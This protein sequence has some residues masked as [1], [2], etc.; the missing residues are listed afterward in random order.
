MA[1]AGEAASNVH[2]VAAAAEELGS[3]VQE[4]G[5]QVGGST[6]LAHLAVSEADQTSVLMHEL[7]SAVARISEPLGHDTADRAGLSDA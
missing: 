6:E 5:R 4:I 1:A 3:S 7:S 2:T